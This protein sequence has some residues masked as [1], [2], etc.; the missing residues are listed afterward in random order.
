MNPLELLN[1]H[2]GAYAKELGEVFRPT[3]VD[4]ASY[5]EEHIVHPAIQADTFYT[6]LDFRTQTFTYVHGLKEALGHSGAFTFGD[7]LQC[8]HPNMLELYLMWGMEAMEMARNYKAAVD[9]F[10]FTYRIALPLRHAN[11]TYLWA[12]QNS[13]AFQLD[14][15]NQLV[16]QLNTYRL[17]VA[18]NEGEITSMKGA[19]FAQQ[20]SPEAWN[21]I[22]SQR[23]EKKILEVFTP[24]EVQLLRSY[25]KGIHNSLEASQHF[26]IT[27]NTIYTHN[28]HITRK[29]SELFQR[30]FHHAVDVA[31]YLKNNGYLSLNT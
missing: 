23:M 27:Q 13:T 2:L 9:P 5:W 3:D 10:K 4:A 7:Y 8:I 31:D 11:G 16:S 15:K 28:K 19:F 30:G 14:E 17:G 26:N 12:F 6:V 22:F 1:Q 25:A 18:L 29:A 21:E 24:K 20:A